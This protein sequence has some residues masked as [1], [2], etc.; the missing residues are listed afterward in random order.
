MAKIQ[1][2]MEITKSEYLARFSKATWVKNAKN[3]LHDGDGTRPSGDEF[4]PEC[5]GHWVI[6]ASSKTAPLVVDQAKN[7]IIDQSQIYGGCFGL[8]VVNFYCYENSGN[9][10]ISCAIDGF[11]KTADGQALGNAVTVDAFDKVAADDL[12]QL[13]AMLM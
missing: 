9:K 8:A 10:G 3:T 5:K 4:G 12:A 2:A 6:T 1:E 13:Q 7:A 11:M